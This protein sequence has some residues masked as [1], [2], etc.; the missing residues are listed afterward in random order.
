MCGDNGIAFNGAG[1]WKFGNDY[2]KNVVI[3]CVN[4]SSSSHT[5]ISKNDFLVLGEGPTCVIN[6]S[7]GPRHK[8]FSLFKTNNKNVNFPTQ[9]CV[10]SISNRFG[11]VESREVSSIKLY[12]S[13]ILKK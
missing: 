11:A 4:D 9:F 1:S 6:G 8:T 10:G 13:N 3:F 2:A 5:D 12:S 7:F